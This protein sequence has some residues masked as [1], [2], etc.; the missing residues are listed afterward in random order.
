MMNEKEGFT[1]IG[2]G[3]HCKWDEEHGLGVL[4]HKGKVMEVGA[5]ETGFSELC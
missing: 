1:A 2:F 5:A 3:F 4:T